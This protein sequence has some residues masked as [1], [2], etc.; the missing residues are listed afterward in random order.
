[1][2]LFFKNILV[3]QAQYQNYDDEW[4]LQKPYVPQLISP[5]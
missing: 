2:L 5:L 1:M 4:T 3:L